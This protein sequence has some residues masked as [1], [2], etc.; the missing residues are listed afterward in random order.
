MQA[1]IR[2]LGLALAGLLG[3][4]SFSLAEP[5]A[6]AQPIAIA[7]P[8]SP[9]DREINERRARFTAE[10]SQ[11]QSV[12]AVVPLLGLVELWE[13]VDNRG[14]ILGLVSDAAAPRGSVHPLVRA[15][16]QAVLHI[17]HG[18]QP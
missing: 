18:H 9:Y 15:Y 3:V 16:A 10:A 1:E 13:L 8:S 11:P 14:A 4:L 2:R 12:A 17:L 6:A 5:V 7:T